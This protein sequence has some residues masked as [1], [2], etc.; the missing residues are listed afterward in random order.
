MNLV[1]ASGK[2]AP[3]ISAPNERHKEH[4]E[5]CLMRLLRELA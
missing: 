1:F 5:L 2:E 3:S 4:K